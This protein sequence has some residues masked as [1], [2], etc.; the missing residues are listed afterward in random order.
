MNLLSEA[1]RSNMSETMTREVEM[2]LQD[3]A[4]EAEQKQQA[5]R[6]TVKKLQQYKQDLIA[7]IHLEKQAR[8][9]ER[10]RLE[11]SVEAVRQ[12]EW[13]K[14]MQD[15][16]F[17]KMKQEEER[18]TDEREKLRERRYALERENRWLL[19]QLE[20]KEDENYE[21]RMS[22]ETDRFIQE[23]A[24]WDRLTRERVDVA[25]ST[26][27]SAAATKQKLLVELKNQASKWMVRNANNQEVSSTQGAPR[28]LRGW[29][30]REEWGK[31]QNTE[32]CLNDHVQSFTCRKEIEQTILLNKRL[33][34]NINKKYEKQMKQLMVEK[35]K[36]EEEIRAA[37]LKEREKLEQKL[38]KEMEKQLKAEMKEQMKQEAEERKQAE[39]LEKKAKKEKREKA[40]V[41]GTEGDRDQ[42]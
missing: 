32:A 5:M 37:A 33:L 13:A 7:S 6:H 9:S 18:L 38:K 23:A 25:L 12:E 26:T 3:M 21:K 15:E 22:K 4:E 10:E 34:A 39:K 24:K 35:T 28:V 2:V 27:L 19:F 1:L 14:H 16:S 36:K 20:L 17:M 42:A 40:A 30:L 29:M 8:E 11:A 41:S 31:L